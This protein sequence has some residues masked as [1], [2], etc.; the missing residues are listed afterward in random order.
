MSEEAIMTTTPDLPVIA[1][2]DGTADGISAA[3]YAAEL[4]EKSARPLVLLHAY[5][6]SAAINPLL[7]VGDPSQFADDWQRALLE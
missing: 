3:Q 2:I 4:A 5:R 6:R 1:G 7:P